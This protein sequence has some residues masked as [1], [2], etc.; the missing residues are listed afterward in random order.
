MDTHTIQNFYKELFSYNHSI[1]T[2]IIDALKSNTDALPEKVFSLFSH[3]QNAH[4]IWNS[5]I[6]NQ[7]STYSVFDTHTIDILE[8]LNE[9]NHV[10]SIE[11]IDNFNLDTLIT[12]TNSKGETFSNTIS[13][14]LFHIINHSTYHRAQIA[15]LFRTSGINPIP[16][17]YITYKR[18]KN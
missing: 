10:Q 14:I 4:H 17:D 5:R 8:K 12:Y 6:K 1:N 3:I 13:E 15:T 7:S 9:D 2:K 18:T 16:T 11:I